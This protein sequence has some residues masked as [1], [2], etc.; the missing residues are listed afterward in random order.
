MRIVGE[1]QSSPNHYY[2]QF[3]HPL[4]KDND[5]TAIGRRVK[6][7]VRDSRTKRQNEEDEEYIHYR[8]DELSFVGSPQEFEKIR[9][10]LEAGYDYC[11]KFAWNGDRGIMT[12]RSSMPF[13]DEDIKRIQSLDGVHFVDYV[14]VEGAKIQHIIAVVIRFGVEQSVI[15][16]AIKEWMNK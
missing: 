4:R 8:G 12:V 16:D 6:R 11:S 1:R 10:L 2:L 9:K 14:S 3:E 13:L 7:L 15:H 5:L